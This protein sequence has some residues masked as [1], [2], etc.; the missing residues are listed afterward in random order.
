MSGS[1]AGARRSP[2]FLALVALTV[3]GVLPLWVGRFLPL[4]D[5][6]AHL[7]VPAAMLHASDPA[8]R[9]DELYLSRPGLNP[10]S[11]HYAVTFLLGHVVPLEVASKLFLSA[12]VAALPWSMVFALR[13][14]GRDWRLVFLAVPMM[15]GRGFFYGF[16]GHCAALPMHL[17][18]VSMLARELRSPAASRRLVVG[19]LMALLPF[20]HFFT[21]LLTFAAGLLVVWRARGSARAVAPLAMGPLVML[22]WFVGALLHPYKARPRGS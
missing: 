21:M 9:I 4:F 12:A 13:T 18:I 19:V 2:E 11:L 6:P 10:N 7:V 5:Y 8:M 16:V 17:V 20:A 3:L 1:H 14:F 22:P 15:L